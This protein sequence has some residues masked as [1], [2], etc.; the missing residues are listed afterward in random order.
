MHASR[1][2]PR[3]DP[4]RPRL[5][6]VP[7]DRR[8]V[9]APAASAAPAATSAAATARRT[10]TPPRISTPPGIRSS[11]ATTRRRAGAGATSTRW[12]STSPTGPR[13]SSDQSR[14]SC[15]CAQPLASATAVAR[16]RT[17]NW[18]DRLG[19]VIP[20]T[21]ASGLRGVWRRCRRWAPRRRRSGSRLRAG[22]ARRR[23]PGAGGA[24]GAG[25]RRRLRLPARR[26][27]ARLRAADLRHRRDG[28]PLC[29]HLLPHRPPARL[30]APDAGRLRDL[31]ARARHRR[32][33]DHALRVLGGHDRSPRG[34]WSGSTT[35]A[36]R[37]GPAALQALLVT[38]ARRRWRCWPG[39]C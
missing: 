31:D 27:G 21:T 24:L 7:E 18:E 35:S 13:R 36:P 1:H 19:R 30:A 28:V 9:G 34:C 37:R 6:G 38:G 8:L 17:R 29:R 23:D 33:R 11:K 39:S 12:P 25:A 22:V 15:D 14:A 20:L 3:R 4:E 2:D 32:R 10:G 26:A 16:R 5:R